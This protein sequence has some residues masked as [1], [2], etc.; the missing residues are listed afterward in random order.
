MKGKR[1]FITENHPAYKR[2][3][4]CEQVLLENDV[5]IF[6]GFITIQDTESGL[7]LIPGSNI[8]ESVQFPRMSDENFY[9]I[10]GE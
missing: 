2:I 4:A 9:I 10:E 8:H 3:L 1:R 6:G 7:S 5:A